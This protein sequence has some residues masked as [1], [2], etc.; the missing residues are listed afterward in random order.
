MKN[1]IFMDIDGTLTGQDGFVPESAKK[2]IK[3]TRDLGNDVILSTGRSLA[4]ITDDILEIGFDGIIGAGGAYIELKGEVI[5][6][7]TMPEQSLHDVTNYLNER[8]IGYYLE[9]NQGL[10]INEYCIPKIKEAAYKLYQTSPELFLNQENP[11]PSWFLDILKK[12]EGKEIPYHDINK[13]S[14]ISTEF[15]FKDIE[16]QFKNEF[17]IY[18]ATV[19]EF[20]PESGEI[21]LKG[22]D[23]KTA[24]NK[25]YRQYD[26]DIK[27]YAYGDGLND[28][29]MFEVVDHAVAMRNA[30]DGLKQIANE[31]IG[32]A[33]EDSIYKSFLKNNLI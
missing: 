17:E 28:V 16:Q 19:F 32:I 3:K 22:I 25:V 7:T 20:G 11:E 4:E 1:V 33:E 26:P 12:S 15:P 31:Q 9:S 13:L 23:K 27:S 29:P 14:F 8:E 18:H 24:I 30:K 10:F 6:H 5:Q 21:G 2:A